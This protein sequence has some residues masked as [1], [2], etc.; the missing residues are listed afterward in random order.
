MSEKIYL[1]ISTMKKHQ[2]EM[3][4]FI[5]KILIYIFIKSI[6]AKVLRTLCTLDEKNIDNE[7]INLQM[8]FAYFVSIASWIEIK[9]NEWNRAIPLSV[10]SGL[11]LTNVHKGNR[12]VKLI[13]GGNELYIFTRRERKRTTK[14]WMYEVYL[15]SA[16]RNRFSSKYKQLLPSGFLSIFNVYFSSWLN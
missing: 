9:P 2:N 4:Y 10:V 5:R 7:D 8:C 6:N 1:K 14:Y 16:F 13:I 11:I 3:K 12:I 15:H